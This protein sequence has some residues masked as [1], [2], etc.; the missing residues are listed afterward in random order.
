M[1]LCEFYILAVSS[2]HQCA[3]VSLPETIAF[4]GCRCPEE[5]HGGG[6]C[7]IWREVPKKPV[8][9]QQMLKCLSMRNWPE[10]NGFQTQNAIVM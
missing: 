2:F 7:C 6:T 10:L 8:A 9:R 1:F 5:K 4:A 3:Y